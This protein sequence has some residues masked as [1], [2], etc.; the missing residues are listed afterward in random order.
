M[1]CCS[2]VRHTRLEPSVTKPKVSSPQ[3]ED[4]VPG[5]VVYVLRPLQHHQLRQNGHSLQVYRESP[6]NLQ[7]TMHTL[8]FRVSSPFHL[9]CLS[10][11]SL[12]GASESQCC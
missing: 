7:V 5:E 10:V 6:Q 1:Q 12:W 8:N 3:Q 2:K 11:S 4:I 9:H